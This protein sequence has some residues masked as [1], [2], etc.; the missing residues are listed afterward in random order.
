MAA[1]AYHVISKEVE[2]H[3]IRDSIEFLDA[4]ASTNNSHR[5]SCGIMKLLDKYNI[6]ISDTFVGS[7]LDVLFLLLALILSEFNEKLRRKD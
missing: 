5:Q 3:I 4:H 6:G 2:N 7:F 1:S